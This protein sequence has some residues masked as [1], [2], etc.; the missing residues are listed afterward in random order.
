MRLI[1]TLLL[2][3]SVL[4]CASIPLSAQNAPAVPTAPGAPAAAFAA[5]PAATNAPA[6]A[7]A[8]PTVDSNGIV[9]T[10]DEL[11]ISDFELNQRVAFMIAVSGFKPTDADIKRMRE[12]MLSRLEEEK[13]QLLEARRQ[14]VTVSPVEVN[15]RIDAFL[16]DNNST[17]EQ[18]TKVLTEAGSSVETLRNQYIAAIAWQQVV[19][20]EFQSDIVITP[21]MIDDGLRRALEGANKPHYRVSE[22]FLPVDRPE[23]ETKVKALIEDIENRLRTGSAFRNM[24]RQFS[25]N[26][27][28]AAGGD[29]GWVYDGQLDSE[30]NSVVAAM[31]ANELSKPIRARGGW[32]LLGLQDRQ[33]PLGTNVNV[34]ETPVPTG[35]PGTLPLVHLLL[36]LPAGVSQVMV[37]NVMKAAMQVRQVAETCEAME[38]ISQDPNLKGS[39]FRNLGNQLLADLHPE[40]QK[41][42]A[43]TRSGEPAMPVV[44]ENGVN[45]FMRCDKKAEPPRAVFKVPTREEIQDRLFQEQI[46]ALVRRYMRDL[47]REASIEREGDNTV[48]DAALVK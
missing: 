36:P 10:V 44:L 37:D 40:L 30:L 2:G 27:S 22:I 7:A 6:P 16:A 48:I 28:A 42:L 31:K 33:E 14:K 15:K 3:A 47:K 45:I 18:L 39:V 8:T 4:A 32:Y 25:R 35:P 1:K 21:A 17:L 46:A 26:P 23:D 9:A 38:K 19:Q 41:A 24:A 43:A 13:T 20:R 5:A 11:S 34:V 29:I 12:E